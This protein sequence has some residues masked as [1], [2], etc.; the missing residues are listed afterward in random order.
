MDSHFSEKDL[1]YMLFLAAQINA[2]TSFK[3]H[4]PLGLA[5]SQKQPGSLIF[6]LMSFTI[7][8]S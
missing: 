7:S 5:V 1:I 8:S 3:Q 6:D 4:L 2:L